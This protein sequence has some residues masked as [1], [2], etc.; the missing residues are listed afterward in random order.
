MKAILVI[1]VTL[2]SFGTNANAQS[3][4]IGGANDES[5]IEVQSCY[6]N[7][8]KVIVNVINDSNDIAANV[9]VGVQVTYRLGNS[10]NT[11]T[12]PYAGK[13]ISLAK[14]STKIE[15]PI[16]EVHPSD[17][18]YVAYSVEATSISGTKCK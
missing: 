17:N 13:E 15:I 18:R 12:Y 4:M 1:L 11:K 14:V 6:L 9:T 3:C 2:A 7:G 8:D 16:H 10:N 5:T